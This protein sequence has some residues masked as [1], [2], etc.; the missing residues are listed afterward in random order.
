MKKNILIIGGSGYIGAKLIDFYLKKKFKV[1][2][3]FS[4]HTKGKIASISAVALGANLIEKHFNLDDKTIE[5][6]LLIFL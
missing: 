5:F 3:G 1:L 6:L 2:A 4:D